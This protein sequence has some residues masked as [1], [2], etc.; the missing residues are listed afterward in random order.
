MTGDTSNRMRTP[1]YTQTFYSLFGKDKG[2]LVIYLHRLLTMPENKLVHILRYTEDVNEERIVDSQDYTPED[3]Q[4]HI[5]I[6]NYFQNYF[7]MNHEEVEWTLAMIRLSLGDLSAL[8]FVLKELGVSSQISLIYQS[9]FADD[10]EQ[11][12]LFRS[13][14]ED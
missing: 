10:Y 7:G 2:Q 13:K 3:I 11:T 4:A 5:E 9:M 8:P 1:H 6:T 12:L 14:L